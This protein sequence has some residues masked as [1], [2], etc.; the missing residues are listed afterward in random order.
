MEINADFT[1]KGFFTVMKIKNVPQH[2]VAGIVHSYM[3]TLDDHDILIGEP[4]TDGT[5]E[6]IVV[7][8]PMGSGTRGS[9][10]AEVVSRLV[11]AERKN[12]LKK[13]VI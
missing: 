1:H 12:V 7:S 5:D 4:Y 11:L 10:F 2:M 8:V 6:I 13:G 3:G 9:G